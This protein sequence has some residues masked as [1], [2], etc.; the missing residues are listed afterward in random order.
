M[1]DMRRLR[2]V[3][4]AIYGLKNR[5]RLIIMND[6]VFA[7]GSNMNISNLKKWLKVNGY[8]DK[9]I[10]NTE[11]AILNGYKIVWNY[12]APNRNGGVANLESDTGS[13]I[14]GVL[15]EIE[16]SLLNAFDKK[17][18]P[19][20]TY[21]RKKEKVTTLLG[22]KVTAWI[23]MAESN[24]NGKSDIWPHWE[25]KKLIIDAAKEHHFPE[26]YIHSLE[27]IPSLE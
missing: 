14:W 12:Y 16:S 25:Y 11:V 19:P 21:F 18:G 10:V 24:C 6:F 7:Y 26:D 1:G 20:V 17:E 5:E 8:D 9:K 3:L 22:L 27:L 13:I 15:I 2:E 4:L 23:Y